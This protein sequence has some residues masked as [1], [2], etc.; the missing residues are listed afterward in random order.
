MLELLRHGVRC[1]M[2]LLMCNQHVQV[3]P[4]PLRMQFLGF[5]CFSTIV[6][7]ESKG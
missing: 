4:V 5:Y 2:R 1:Q 6:Q 3:E 7:P